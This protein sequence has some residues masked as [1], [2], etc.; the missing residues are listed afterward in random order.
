MMKLKVCGMR[1]AENI[2]SLLNVKPDF[3]GMIFYPKSSRFVTTTPEINFGD[4]PKVGVFVNASI[5]EI[6]EKALQYD[7]KWLQLHGNEPVEQVKELKEKGYQVIKV[8]SV[9][10]SLP[11]E[12]MM[13]YEPYVDY[14]L[15]DT[16]TP[17]YGG[18][19]HQFDWSILK[20]Y[21]LKKP[22]FLS[23]GIDLDDIEKIKEMN[24][25]LLY[26]I[27][28]NSRFELSPAVKDIEKIK[29]LKAKL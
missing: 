28:V 3:I 22:F 6:E 29:A 24:L 19:G 17:K 27:D 16:K 10:D 1:E 14:F 11:T 20:G 26:A 21:G 18:S 2:Q 9:L 13:L 25:E 8:F 15:F 23:G 12:Q 7:L 4:I 5:T